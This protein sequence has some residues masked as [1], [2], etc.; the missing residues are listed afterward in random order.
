[1]AAVYKSVSK[2]Q[3]KQLAREQE[4]DDSDAEMADLANLLDDADD[5]SDSEDEEEENL[6][7][8]KKQLAAGYMPKT[9]VLMLTSRGITSRHRHLLADLA[10]L[11]PHT[12]KESKLDTKKKTAGYNLLLNDLAD[13]H[14][15][16]VIFFLEARKRGQDLYLWLAR[17]PN[18]PTLKFHVNNLHT[19]SE[20][21]A[22]FSGN[23]LKGGRGVVV[24]DR[25][26][27][28]QGPL[29]SQP[30]NEY[31]GLVREMLR[32]VFSVPKRGVK[33]M[34]PFIDRIIGV[35]GVDGKIW[36]RVYEIRESEAGGKKK[37]EEGEEAGKPVPKGKDGLP[38]V[39]LVEVG[40]RFV[41]TPIVILEGSFGGPVIYENKEYVSPNQVRHDIRINKAA[42][43]AK[44]R[45]VQTD[46]FAKRT[47]LG[48][49]EGQR[50]PDALDNRQFSST[51]G[52]LPLSTAMASFSPLSPLRLS[53]LDLHITM[54]MSFNHLATELLLHVFQYC[55]TISD[56]LSLSSTCR[57][58]RTVF[59]RSN[60]LQI[61]ADIAE[62]EFGPLDEII[63]IVTQN[64]SQAAHLIRKP[65]MSY[66][67]LKQVVQAG[68]VAQKWEMIYPVKKWKVDYENRRSLTNDERFRLR[69]AIYRLWLYHRAFHTRTHDRFSR[70]LPH[71][72]AERAQL[73]HNWS[74]QE[75]ADIE[76][77]RLIISDVVQNHI[78][79]SNG[80]IQRKFRKRF[81]ENHH[82]LAFNIHLN[83]PAT[84]PLGSSGLFDSPSTVDQYYYIAHPASRTESPAKYRS[85]FRNDFFHDPGAEGWGDEIPHY[86][87]VQDMMK[88]DPG[89]VL[90]LREHAPLKEQVE[91][92][93]H[94]LGDWFRDNGETFGD[95]LE[96]VMKERG[97]NIEDLRAAICDWEVG[98][99]SD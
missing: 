7:S 29:M 1:M 86:Y 85:K 18:G 8:A 97:D 32:G 47:D 9:R 72:V 38:E 31:R 25:S 68:R 81:P 50:K 15:C 36:I 43:H 56:V 48:L 55:D 19:M 14:S 44:R 13:L 23:C 93:V 69:Q 40:P 92:Y 57:R 5:T 74:T 28:E 90:W 65:P 22:G 62:R 30:G 61:L 82:Q 27:D 70:K 99:V 10:G 11:L 24:F 46:R 73:L 71:V 3:A 87:V 66:P 60:K 2:K 53:G 78:C 6:E 35:F 84:S 77:V 16:N 12:H 51:P 42:R 80:T 91:G 21:N 17:P 26:F 33:G 96:W 98:V 75:L 49:G 41:L 88:L 76:D 45:E 39:S 83:Y 52:S 37:S 34:K 59:N 89:Q 67:L 4:M 94:S 64:A 63:Q 20:L 79:P 54:S 95:T 58:L